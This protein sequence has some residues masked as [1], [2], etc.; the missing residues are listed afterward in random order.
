[1]KV[2]TWVMVNGATLIAALQVITK[3]VKELL[4]GV[5]NVISLFLSAEQAERAVKAVRA[6]INTV[7]DVLE[8][9]K[10]LWLNV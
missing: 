7:D 2:I 1:M 5:V 10:G 4:T 6:I 9:I 8:K 3:A